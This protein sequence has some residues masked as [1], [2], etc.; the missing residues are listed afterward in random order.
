M[1]KEA[2][3]NGETA[4]AI[5]FLNFIEGDAGLLGKT[6]HFYLPNGKKP[7]QEHS[8]Q[9]AAVGDNYSN[10]AYFA[11][12]LPPEMIVSEKYAEKLM[13]EL[14]TELI[15]VEYE[16]A[17]SKETEKQ[18]KAI[19]KGEKQVSHESKLERYSEMKNSEIQVKVLGNSI[20]F[21]I[22]ML[23]V[24][25]YLNMMA[26]PV[27]LYQRTQNASIIERLRNCED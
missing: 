26:A 4:V 27:V 20:G 11:G 9:I 17:F 12:G 6:V 25:N 19:F 1:D 23:A 7:T 2:F 16:D 10:P 21:I 5:K 18:V 24:L 3:K 13:G 8:I 15:N 22:A 14:F